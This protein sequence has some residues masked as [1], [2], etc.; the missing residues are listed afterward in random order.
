MSEIQRPFKFLHD[1][2][3]Q[4][5]Y[6][7][8]PRFLMNKKNEIGEKINKFQGVSTSIY[9]YFILIQTISFSLKEN[10][11]ILVENEEDVRSKEFELDIL[12]TGHVKYYNHNKEYIEIKCLNESLINP[13]TYNCILLEY[14]WKIVKSFN[15]DLKN[16]DI[17]CKRGLEPTINKE[18]LLATFIPNL[19]NK[20]IIYTEFP[21]IKEKKYLQGAKTL[22]DIPQYIEGM[23]EG[24][25]I[26][27]TT[28]EAGKI[29]KYEAKK[30]LQKLNENI[31]D[32]NGIIKF[33][34]IEEESSD[35]GESDGEEENSINDD[36]KEFYNPFPKNGHNFCHLC[37]NNFKDYNE[38]VEGKMHKEF[39][40]KNYFIVDRIKMSF[41]RINDFWDI[42]NGKEIKPRN[43]KN[44]INLAKTKK[45][46]NNLNGSIV[47]NSIKD[48]EMSTTKEGSSQDNQHKKCK[49]KV[50]LISNNNI[51]NVIKKINISKNINARKIINS[52]RI[53]NNENKN[54]D[55]KIIENKIIENKNIFN[56][57]KNNI[58]K[59]KLNEEK[60]ESTNKIIKV[61]PTSTINTIIKNNINEYLIKNNNCD[62]NINQNKKQDLCKSEEKKS[63]NLKNIKINNLT[64]QKRNKNRSSVKTVKNKKIRFVTSLELPTFNINKID[65]PQTLVKPQVVR[66]KR[67]KNEFEKFTKLFIVQTPKK[68]IKDY[69]KTLNADNSKIMFKKKVL[70]HQIYVKII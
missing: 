17:L 19:D 41:E 61:N 66:K 18:S 33:M 31:N 55:N 8:L 45:N 59:K 40:D 44:V 39:L 3:N 51:K 30:S 7:F 36:T 11:Y 32:E 70:F 54:N 14:F 52:K 2:K 20:K 47:N 34:Q 56:T 57:N 42:K 22:Y 28:W 9:F 21:K 60:K 4:Y 12:N 38:H 37:R 29:R 25:S 24:F 53:K 26:F 10:I 13:P 15:T 49:K 1:F 67:R 69:F 64:V 5:F 23:P 6:Y 50:L 48:E 65:K 46:K 43:K 68:E 58:N 62:D 63:K 27:C 16:F 35:S